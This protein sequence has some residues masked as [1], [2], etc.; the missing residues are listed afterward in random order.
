MCVSIASVGVN[1]MGLARDV[2]IRLLLTLLGLFVMGCSPDDTP[3]QPP[4]G[5][6]QL[7][8]PCAKTEDC[9]SGLCVRVNA[10]SGVCT[11][12]C[13]NDAQCPTS[14]NWT[15][16]QSSVG[17]RVCACRELAKSEVCAD[18]L[19][20]NCDARI[21]DC[22]VCN[23]V[24]V[25]NDDPKHCGQCGRACHSDQRCTN[26]S[27]VCPAEHPQDCGGACANTQ[28]DS[29]NCGSCGTACG[30]EQVCSGGACV[31]MDA[32]Q[33]DYCAGVGCVD[34]Q[35]DVDHCGA[36]DKACTLG[37]VCRAGS[38]ACP[39]GAPPN[40]CP[41]IGCVDFQANNNHCGGC[42]KKCEGGKLCK[43]GACACPTG[44]TDCDGT[45]VDT[46]ND[47]RHCGACGKACTAAQA[48][49]DSTCGCVAFGMTICGDEC[50]DLDSSASHCGACDKACAPGE[51]CATKSCVCDSGLY[52]NGACVAYND[53]ANCGSCGHAC[54]ASQFCSTSACFCQG[55]GLSACGSACVNLSS[56]DANC[57]ECGRACLSGQSC[58]G[59]SC[60]CPGGGSYCAEANGCVDLSSDPAH[61]GAC[62]A[63]CK[64]TEV[65]SNGTCHC[66]GAGSGEEYCA[67]VGACVDT[68]NSPSHCGGCDLAC[69]PTEICSGSCFCPDGHQ[70]YCA[71]RNACTDVFE[72]N[73]HCG[74]CDKPCPSG[75]FCTSGMCWCNQPRETLCGTTCYDLANDPKHCGTCTNA[76][77]GSYVCASGECKCP[78]PT[79]GTA[80]RLTNN[81]IDEFA[82]AVAW[83][84][85]HFGVAYAQRIGTGGGTVFA[86]LR[87]ALLN[88]NGSVVSDQA[89]TNYTSVG[90]T[91]GPSLVWSGSEYALV[92]A[93]VSSGQFLRLDATGAPKGTAVAVGSGSV[94][95][96][97]VAW[98][99]SYGGYAVAYIDTSNT[100]V[101]F[102]RIGADATSPEAV[103]SLVGV[104]ANKE[105]NL[106]LRTAP[107]GTWA[108]GSGALQQPQLTIF[109][110]DG[111]RTLPLQT[112]SNT[113]PYSGPVYP[114]LVYDGSQW[115]TAWVSGATTNVVVNRGNAANSPVNAVTIG[116]AANIGE[117]V[118]AM[119][120]GTLALGWIERPSTTG[121]YSFR[122]QRYAIPSTTSSF[123]TPIHNAI[124][125][126][127]TQNTG[128]GD[129]A[130]APTS[131]AL[132]AV[133]ADNRWGATR[134]IYA[135]PI[136]LGSCP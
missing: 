59:G 110:A 66:P 63:P 84:G 19:D 122:L 49:Q 36:C 7:G 46:G 11:A 77:P 33:P 70:L 25:T 86:N 97:S 9:A 117:A 109:N 91:S 130:L 108:V 107:N 120:K 34:F 27:C 104:G 75:T 28:T 51:R 18:G 76:C 87:F 48:C 112:L 32:A 82:P 41:D 136:N 42:G 101:N 67:S 62:G 98:S 65:C 132:I 92:W 100:S 103:N 50:V 3:A 79:V 125:V 20:N 23:G 45:C 85:T 69:N 21:D 54:S 12:A 134:E 129:V 38:C 94:A 29:N 2:V 73:Q 61:C 55:Y 123:V 10:S 133:W 15:C 72:N 81:S 78:D 135:A 47:A 56:D 52:C 39:E 40:F 43:E 35:N 127:T 6:G 88:L 128:L 89:L 31:C 68:R 14:N 113:A 1:A 8:S 83:D 24:Q 126:L 119:V 106:V 93:Y 22:R 64:P 60:I 124:D 26:G 116:A 74:A 115:L 95:N 111:S 99:S 121:A 105:K 96:P 114:D 30:L 71:S 13:E 37:Q 80:V 5:P 57:G 44:Q 58:I 17:F 118:L 90:M 4:R 102:V 131:N 53:N 16:A